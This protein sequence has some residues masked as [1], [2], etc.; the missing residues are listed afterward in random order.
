MKYIVL[1]LFFVLN[2]FGSWDTNP[3]SDT[4]SAFFALG[5]GETQKDAQD[6]ALSSI[7]SRI[8]VNLSSEFNNEVTVTKQG[9]DEMILEDSTNT[10][11]S[12][13]SKIEFSDVVVMHTK[14][15]NGEFVVLVRVDKDTLLNNYL[16]KLQNITKKINQKYKKLKHTSAFNKIVLDADITALMKKVK[17]LSP[18]IVALDTKNRWKKIENKFQ[19]IQNYVEE[20]RD[21]I[22]FA[23]QSDKNSKTLAYLVEEKLQELG[24]QIV[25]KHPSLYIKFITKAKKRKIHSTNERFAKLTFALKKATIELFDAKHKRKSRVIYKT[26]EASPNGFKDALA[27]TTK[28]KKKISQLGI[29]YFLVGKKEV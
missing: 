18:V 26:K 3:P 17:Q 19:K 13:T 6:D 21:T 11:N 14:K 15:T 8:F 29:I 12:Q 23:L 28:Y 7:S 9:N 25:Q 20:Q 16:H 4:S 5:Y 22:S 1:S 10:V 2:L 24:Y 27:K